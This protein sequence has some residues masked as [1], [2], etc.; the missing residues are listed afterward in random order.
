MKKTFK[1]IALLFISF[2]LLS[3]GQSI[4]VISK[5][6]S[7]TAA[8]DYGK[9]NGP[10]AYIAGEPNKKY[11]SI[12]KA[13][14]V[15]G[16]DL[17]ANT[18]YVIPGTN[19][20][21]TSDCE[22]ANGDTLCLPYEGTTW[23][24]GAPDTNLSDKFIDSNNTNVNKYRATKVILQNSTLKVNSGGTLII[25][26]KF[27][28]KGVCGLYCE[29][30]LDSN[31]HIDV[32]GSMTNYG[33]IKEVDGKNPYQD[34]F[35]D[36]ENKFNNEIDNNRYIEVF[37]G[38]KFK[39]S[40][41]VY[42]NLGTSYLSGLNDIGIC[43]VDTFDFP[44]TQTYV[45]I[46]SGAIFQAQAKILVTSS[47]ANKAVNETTTIISTKSIATSDNSKPLFYLESGYMS[48]E[49]CPT[50]ILYSNEN[51]KTVINISGQLNMGYLF[52]DLNVAEINTSSMFL[53]LG[54]K[55]SI[56]VISNGIFSSDYKLKFLAGSKLKVDKG[57]SAVL[58][59]DTILY[60]SNTMND[61]STTYPTDQDDAVFI[62]NGELKLGSNSHIGG[63]IST[64][65]S[66]GTAMIDASNVTSNN[67]S[68]TSNEGTS[69]TPITFKATG[70]F[71][72][73]DSSSIE[74]KQFASGQIIYS[75]SDGHECW[76]NGY[77]SSYSLIIKV[78]NPYNYDYPA[79]AFKAYQY[80]SSGSNESLLSS[81]GKFETSVGTYEYL[82]QSN[83]KFKVVSLPRA[84]TSVFTDQIG[85]NYSFTSGELYTIL[86]DIE[87]TI[88]CG[89][90]FE[91]WFTSSSQSGNGG[92][93]KEIMESSTES[94]TF[95]TLLVGGA[96]G[97]K[98]KVV[99][100]K[101]Q[102]FKYR[103]TKG[104][105]T[106][107]FKGIYKFDGHHEDVSSNTNGALVGANGS[108]TTSNAV[109]ADK[110]YTLLAYMEAGGCFAEKTNI[111][112]SDGSSKKIE[113]I[114]KGD[115]VLTWNFFTG[116]YEVQ[117]VAFVV[118]HGLELYKTVRLSFSNDQD[119]KII[120][121]H[122]FFDYDLNKY[123]YITADNYSDYIGHQFVVYSD[124]ESYTLASLDS[125]CISEEYTTAYS[126]TTEYNYN[127]I[128]NNL[129]TAPPPENLYN[130][131]EMSGKLQYDVDKFEEDI[132]IYGL[133]DYSVFAPYGI[134]EYTFN[135][136]NGAY[137]KIPVEKGL[138]TFEYIIEQFNL[139]KDWIN[140]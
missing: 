121:D 32:Y 108:S 57:A 29:L 87:L 80:D 49:N 102:Y 51:S 93:T 22:I 8:Y 28:A 50:D 61:F 83:Q 136:F 72:I 21:I 135:T 41:A 60:K 99:I 105:G 125:G 19:P 66:D 92:S 56:N 55:L 27:R 107:S 98:E 84:K 127:V 17:N 112:L 3:N 52:I 85:S 120:A 95:E 1:N 11:T 111:M 94:G 126:I 34:E 6:A 4:W 10:V 26:G 96:N 67:L 40:L 36:I 130:W 82:L 69:N 38:G 14:K 132:A 37:S 118:N 64:N 54:Y 65:S 74:K 30:S 106:A 31:S 138:F 43:P 117:K 46:N 97:S 53:P 45:K 103:Y 91:M 71:Y 81:E 88:T 115:S 86:G 25:G 63:H 16:D 114:T 104:T 122:G 33:Y 68:A 5:S 77:V 109:L 2:F 7:G 20:T 129:F 134:S 12:E 79:A 24:Y 76:A 44:N 137:L 131:M 119:I 75:C 9:K 58:N 123:V 39:N 140:D 101:N 124:S 23:D 89:E 139:Y 18:I 48:I 47:V 35:I 70:D 15:A 116:S 13:L 100:G 73:S 62:N 90:G 110:E 59:S 128:A 113:N 42:N 78:I 133:Y